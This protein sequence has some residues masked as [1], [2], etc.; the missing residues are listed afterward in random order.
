LSKKDAKFAKIRKDLE[1]ARQDLDKHIKSKG[2]NT[3]LS[4]KDMKAI[5]RGELPDWL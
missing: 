2:A 4:K 1:K 5:Q 3:K